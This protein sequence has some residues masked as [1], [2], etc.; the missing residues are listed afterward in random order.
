MPEIDRAAWPYRAL[1]EA[2]WWTEQRTGALY[3]RRAERREAAD[4]DPDADVPWWLDRA[5]SVTYAQ[6]K[7]AERRALATIPMRL[8]DGTYDLQRAE[9]GGPLL[10]LSQ[11]LGNRNRLPWWPFLRGNDGL[12]GRQRWASARRYQR[13]TRAGARRA[14]HRLAHRS[15][16]A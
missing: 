8:G 1:I 13:I 12:T 5:L 4:L 6:R 10:P 7:V 3:Q 9:W 14:A 16:G 2:W 15:H 11:R